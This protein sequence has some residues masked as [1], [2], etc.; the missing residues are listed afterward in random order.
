MERSIAFLVYLVSALQPTQLEVAVDDGCNFQYLLNGEGRSWTAVIAQTRG[1]RLVPVR[2]LRKDIVTSTGKRRQAPHLEIGGNVGRAPFPLFLVSGGPVEWQAS[3]FLTWYPD[4]HRFVTDRPEPLGVLF[5][6]EQRVY[7]YEK[8]DARLLR[9]YAIGE[10]SRSG[11]D[12]CFE[13]YN[14]HVE[15]QDQPGANQTIYSARRVC[16]PS[17]P[18]LLWAGDLDRDEVADLLFRFP[19]DQESFDVTLYLSH[20]GQTG[21]VLRKTATRRIRKCLPTD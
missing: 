17:L 19:V 8:C 10:A 7:V 5:P 9:L 21:S 16:G 2:I 4:S 15:L 18:E 1:T 12:L 11:D 13:N 14:L 20:F 6:G 3:L